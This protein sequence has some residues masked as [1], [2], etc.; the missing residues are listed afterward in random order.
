MFSNRQEVYRTRIRERLSITEREIEREREF[1][2][3]SL[4]WLILY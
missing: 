1:T 2:I 4:L 3:H